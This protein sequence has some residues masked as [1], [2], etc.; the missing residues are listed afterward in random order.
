LLEGQ[1]E[2]Q[3]E[4]YPA[5]T[6]RLIPEEVEH[7]PFTAKTGAVIMITWCKMEKQK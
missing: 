7:G 3:G 2:S 5:G 4:V 6:F 1:Y